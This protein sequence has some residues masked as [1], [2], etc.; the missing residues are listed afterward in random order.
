M[1]KLALALATSSLLAAPLAMA[2]CNSE[3]DR[4]ESRVEQSG[5]SPQQKQRL[6]EWIDDRRDEFRYATPQECAQIAAEINRQMTDYGYFSATG[7]GQ[8]PGFAGSDPGEADL[9]A[10]EIAVTAPASDIGIDQPA[11]QVDVRYPAPEVDVQMQSPQIVIQVP[12]PDIQVTQQQPEI[13]VTQAEPRVSVRQGEPEIRV[14]QP[15]PVV[16]V[17]HAEP[18]VEIRR[19]GASMQA[20]QAQSHAETG[21]PQPQAQPP[22]VVTVDP[23]VPVADAQAAAPA[24]PLPRETRE[25]VMPEVGPTRQLAAGQV[26][27]A[28]QLRGVTVINIEGHV[29]G[30][31]SEVLTERDSERVL[32]RIQANQSIGLNARQLLIDT[33]DLERN[34]GNLLVRSSLRDLEQVGPIDDDRLRPA[35]TEQVQLAGSDDE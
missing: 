20:G 8:Q 27:D 25:A 24:R 14:H 22:A 11:A 12:E 3:L 5:T 35:L 16:S 31:V 23:S 10:L 18:Q 13:F 9:E 30:I 34:A 33:A 17:Q 7:G 6:L 4:I 32:V 19:G 2:N 29:L 1:R 26:V 21:Q 28:A 15:D